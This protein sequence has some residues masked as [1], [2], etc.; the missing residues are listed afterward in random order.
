MFTIDD[1]TAVEQAILALQ[2]GKRVTSVTYGDT[3]VQYASMSLA[4][5]L[6][7]RTQIKGALNDDGQGKKRQ[8]I[9]S[10]TKGLR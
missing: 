8:V 7:L 2:T 1:L 5:L 4:D 9:F 10:T 3:S 6:R